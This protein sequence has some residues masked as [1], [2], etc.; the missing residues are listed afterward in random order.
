[1]PELLFVNVQNPGEAISAVKAL[2][3]ASAAGQRIYQITSAY[4]LNTSADERQLS[5]VQSPFG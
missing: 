5:V 3:K 4:I 2:Q 1:V